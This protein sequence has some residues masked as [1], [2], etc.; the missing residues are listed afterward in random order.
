MKKRFK[1]F[2]VG[3]CALTMAFG[4]NTLGAYAAI[5]YEVEIRT[6]TQPFAA[7]EQMLNCYTSEAKPKSGTQISTWSRT[8]NDSQLWVI[9]WESN[10]YRS[11]RSRANTAVAINANRSYVG[12]VCNVLATTGNNINDY[13][14]LVIPNEYQL[15]GLVMRSRLN[16]TSNVY[17][18]RT[19]TNSL[20]YW[21]YHDGTINQRWSQ[22]E[23]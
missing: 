15:G 23:L 6:T 21:R 2:C 22:S 12:T 14:F 3:L 5:P 20:C 9:Q 11:I 18:T 1:R 7:G 10:G 8:G 4:V 16:H 13:T 17:I 19:G